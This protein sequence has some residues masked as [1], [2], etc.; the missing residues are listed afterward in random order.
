VRAAGGGNLDLWLWLW[1]LLLLLLLLLLVKQCC[2]HGISIQWPDPLATTA[3][4]VLFI[5]PFVVAIWIHLVCTVGR[6]L[7][8]LRDHLS[9]A[10]RPAAT[11]GGWRRRP[12]PARA[13]V[14]AT[15]RILDA[16]PT[17][18]RACRRGLFG[19]HPGWLMMD[20]ENDTNVTRRRLKLATRTRATG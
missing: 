20:G 13:Q 15:R 9:L 16:R 10:Q 11:P 12:V 6:K 19:G 18:R 14:V 3:A 2:V 7:S 8:R 17:S 4:A 1:L 5:I